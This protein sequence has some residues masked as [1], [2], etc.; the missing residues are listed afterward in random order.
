[1]T[2]FV[3]S[4]QWLVTPDMMTV[5]YNRNKCFDSSGGVFDL[6][7]VHTSRVPCFSSFELIGGV[8]E[9]LHREGRHRVLWLVAT[10][11]V[12]VCLRR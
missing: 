11:L 10:V 2:L 3:V 8:V 4:R 9:F 7:S 12:F 1:M 5:L 6:L